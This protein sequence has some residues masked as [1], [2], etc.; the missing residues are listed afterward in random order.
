MSAIGTALRLHLISAGVSTPIHPTRAPQEATP[1]YIVY[2]VRTN[3]DHDLTGPSG[4]AFSDITYAVHAETHPAA[5]TIAS[6]LENTLD[7]LTG[8]VQGTKIAV[9]LHQSTD[10]SGV[11]EADSHPIF[12]IAF[13]VIWYP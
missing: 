7:A 3:I 5:R 11:D 10:D 8:V 12:I 6:T 4:L 1:P 13:R 9:V 2:A